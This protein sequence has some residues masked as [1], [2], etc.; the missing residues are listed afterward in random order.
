MNGLFKL[1]NLDVELCVDPQFESRL[2]YS[3]C[4]PLRS[5]ATGLIYLALDDGLFSSFHL[6]SSQVLR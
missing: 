5:R 6:P 3:T 1:I 4:W 2:Y